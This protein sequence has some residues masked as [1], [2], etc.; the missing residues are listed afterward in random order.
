MEPVQGV[1]FAKVERQ[2]IEM[3]HDVTVDALGEMPECL[4]LLASLLLFEHVPALLNCA[5]FCASCLTSESDPA[6]PC[7]M[8]L[9]CSP[10]SDASECPFD[11]PTAAALTWPLRWVLLPAHLSLLF[12]CTSLPTFCRTSPSA[13][14]PSPCYMAAPLALPRAAALAQLSN[15]P[16]PLYPAAPLPSCGLYLQR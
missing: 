8:H 15:A 9:C 16:V 3:R 7:C 5:S 2:L 10:S 4:C 11:A 6:R 13:P 12:Y 14:P 1:D